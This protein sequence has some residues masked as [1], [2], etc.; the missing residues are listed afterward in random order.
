MTNPSEALT[1]P[2]HRRIA[3]TI[4]WFSYAT[5]KRVLDLVLSLAVAIVTLPLWVAI[6]IAIKLDSPG[7]VFFKQDRV[8]LNG[9]HFRCFKF[10]SMIVNAE[11]MLDEMRR[12]GEVTGLVFKIRNDP[13]VTRVGRLLRKSS[14][15]ELPQLI[16]VLKGEMSLVGPRPVIPAHIKEFQPEDLVRL[17]VKP[18]V[19][20]LWALRGRTCGIEQ[21]M[22]ADREYVL[23]RSLWLDVWI[24]IQTAV[25]VARGENY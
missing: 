10:R 16:N 13:R 5:L 11:A 1:L 2:A 9:R 25:V 6:V 20:C 8:G 19:T 3:I 17:T 21:V 23:R 15:D 18:G 22:T 24:M 12:R 14:L 4:E 7:P